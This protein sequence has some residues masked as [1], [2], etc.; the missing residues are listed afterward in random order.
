MT[1]NELVGTKREHLPHVV[2]DLLGEGVVGEH[3][4]EIVLLHWVH[5]RWS[6]S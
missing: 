6:T 1:T 2:F 3:G 5:R 4:V